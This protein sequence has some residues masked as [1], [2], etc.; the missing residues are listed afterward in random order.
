MSESGE[1]LGREKRGTGGGGRRIEDDTGIDVWAD[2]NN[3]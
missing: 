1:E 3:C 2:I